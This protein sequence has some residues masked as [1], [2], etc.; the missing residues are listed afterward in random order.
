MSLEPV[1]IRLHP[2]TYRAPLYLKE[3][4][5]ATMAKDSLL[6]L[7]RDIKTTEMIGLEINTTIA[8]TIIEME[9]IATV[10]TGEMT[11]VTADKAMVAKTITT[12]ATQTTTV[13]TTETVETVSKILVENV[14][15]TTMIAL[16][17]TVH[18]KSIVSLSTTNLTT[19]NFT[20]T[21]HNSS[22]E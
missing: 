2:P 21:I 1:K 7:N 19:A 12:S 17:R 10:L 3:I 9:I 5:L 16:D 13:E 20:A 8:G 4:R 15:S 14:V 6:A 18:D 11:V 22:L